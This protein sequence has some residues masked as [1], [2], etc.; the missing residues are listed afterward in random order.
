MSPIVEHGI[1]VEV[2]EVVA[3]DE[4][5][6]DVLAGA[7]S[8]SLGDA[9]DFNEDGGLLLLGSEVLTYTS[10]DL[11][12]DTVTLAVG[13]V[14]G[15]SAGD[16]V[17]PYP[18]IRERLAVVDL[19][20]DGD[21]VS[22]R[23]PHSLYDRLPEGIRDELDPEAVSVVL[24][25]SEWVVSD[26]MGR[27]PLVDGSYLDPTT[28]PFPPPT[29][30]TPLSDGLA[31]ATSPTPT[32]IGGLGV[33]HVRWDAIANADPV[34]YEVHVSTV[35]G[36]TP[37]ATTLTQ[38]TASTA[39]T[40]KAL[41]DGTSLAYGPEATPTT[42]FVRLVAK[43]RD[44]GKA[45]ASPEVSGQLHRVGTTEVS[46]Q[47]VYA[48]E[49][50]A[51]KITAGD[52]DVDVTVSGQVA[53][54]LSGR[55][56]ALD[57]TG[58]HLFDSTG[59]SLVD[60]PTDAAKSADFKGSATITSLT[61]TDS[62]SVSTKGSVGSGAGLE[63]AGGVTAPASGPT[64]TLDHPLSS[65]PFTGATP[66]TGSG[67]QYALHATTDG[68]SAFV[69]FYE[70][71]AYSLQVF[72]LAGG[73][74]TAT[75][76]PFSTFL[77]GSVYDYSVGGITY[78][79]GFLY[80]LMQRPS[81]LAWV[82]R[83]Y[84]ATTGAYQ[85]VQVVLGNGDFHWTNVIYTVGLAVSGNNLWV[86]AWEDLG[87]G[88][89][90]TYRIYAT[91]MASGAA[92]QTAPAI[93]GPNLGALTQAQK[94]VARG[95]LRGTFDYGDGLTR[96][97]VNVNGQAHVFTAPGAG[98]AAARRTQDEWDFG[99]DGVVS[100]TGAWFYG[101]GSFRQ[102]RRSQAVTTTVP[103]WDWKTFTGLLWLTTDPDTWWASYTWRDSVGTIHE[104][105]EGARTSFT[106]KRRYRVNL[107]SSALPTSPGVDDP[108]AVSF[109]LGR[110]ATTPVRTD[111]HLQGGTIPNGQTTLVLSTVD[112]TTAAPPDPTNTAL[113]FPGGTT[114]GYLQS[115]A[116]R[117]D[118]NPKVKLDGLGAANVDG[119]LPPGS[120][121]L[122]AGAVPVPATSVPGWLLCD[123][124]QYSQV[125]YPD[126]FNA[127]G[128][129]FNTGGETAGFFRVPDLTDRFPMGAS[130]TKAR[131]ARGGVTG[132][133]VTLAPANL[134]PHAHDMTH[135]HLLNISA[136][137]GTAG[138]AM[139]GVVATGT[140][141]AVNTYS[142][143]TDNGPGTS[144]Q[145]DVLNPYLAL[146][147]LIKT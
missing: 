55:R 51:D 76:D 15:H 137:A 92:G 72:P 44:P 75:W 145:L 35:T 118:G 77:T 42:Y 22:C 7:T 61:V 147:Y 70:S 136:T 146:N 33:L 90:N 115:G 104:T 78:D 83:K 54:A 91:T 16:P 102:L 28:V 112:F 65:S 39:A 23:V 31:P 5:A 88:L 116:K 117:A 101:G 142:G 85:N 127:L 64:V 128:T 1:V 40:I 99:V 122:Y 32:V 13:P 109:Y 134:P 94:I 56:V 38:E 139:R 29:P 111:M 12:T 24:D 36:F 26:V 60:I 82:V 144:A 93:S 120:L 10:A 49:L 53:T 6:A 30:P 74:R 133:K 95:L 131:G 66:V 48:G 110:K 124:G 34:T 121:T 97:V 135:T 79:G 71:G 106:A 11:E 114:P 20:D 59:K 81:D 113:L 68:T 52:L 84:S 62:L 19:G 108:N 87:D 47:Y 57:A 9:V 14:A 63:L 130:G 107:A 86:G 17:Q 138:S 69:V 105:V 41:H 67:T 126:L 37:D 129:T 2:R 50:S 125:L 119:L 80:L 45:P 141:A 4:L 140:N 103:A 27:Q 143:N 123:G 18:T 25:G 58:V 100:N 21:A 89:G 8:L 3:G 46:A 132:G 43:D 96:Y 98:T 73:A